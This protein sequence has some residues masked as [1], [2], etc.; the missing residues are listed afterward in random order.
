VT[1]Q[2]AT[3]ADAYVRMLTFITIDNVRFQIR[4]DVAHFDRNR[5]DI[6]IE[7][8][9]QASEV[10][11]KLRL[12]ERF[13]VHVEFN[14]YTVSQMW[15]PWTDNTFYIRARFYYPP[16]VLS[17]NGVYTLKVSPGSFPALNKLN[18]DAPFLT[19]ALRR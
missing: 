14:L 2:T 10:F 6:G 7:Y 16:P 17:I 4:P 11:E 8:S 15:I 9:E 13:K 18:R 12:F 1:D 5:L 19:L 3:T